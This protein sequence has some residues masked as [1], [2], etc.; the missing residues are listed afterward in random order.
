MEIT[1]AGLGVYETPAD[2]LLDVPAVDGVYEAGAWAGCPDAGLGC[3]E[4]DALPLEP[5]SRGQE[6]RSFS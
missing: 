5:V 4:L 1:L 3:I 2:E 6:E